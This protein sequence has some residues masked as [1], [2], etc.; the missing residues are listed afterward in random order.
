MGQSVW[1]LPCAEEVNELVDRGTMRLQVAMVLLGEIPHQHM[2]RDVVLGKPR[3]DFL[4]DERPGLI[5]NAKGA[6][7]RVVVGDRDERH[8]AASARVVD[9]LGRRVRLRQPSPAKREVAAVRRVTRVDVKIAALHWIVHLCRCSASSGR[10]SPVCAARRRS[11]TRSSPH[12]R[13]S[14][15][16]KTRST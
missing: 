14:T 16:G 15:E 5:G 3:G 1:K 12:L 8:P 2:Q 7:D 11:E 4:A 9:V 10:K 13:Q 6:F